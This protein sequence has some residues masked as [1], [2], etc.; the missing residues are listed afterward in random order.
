MF[1]QLFLTATIRPQS[2]SINV[3]RAS[4]L[5]FFVAR[6][7][8]TIPWVQV[9]PDGT[10]SIRRFMLRRGNFIENTIRK[11]SRC[12]LQCGVDKASRVS[13]MAPIAGA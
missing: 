10:S 3:I 12:V 11:Q 2:T 7:P 13:A 4:G 5:D 9:P 6:S 8:G 1:C